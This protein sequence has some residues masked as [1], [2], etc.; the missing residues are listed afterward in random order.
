MEVGGQRHPPTALSP[1]KI[2]GTHCVGDWA[3]RSPGLDMY[4]KSRPDILETGNS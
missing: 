4:R 3:G 1:V 2:L